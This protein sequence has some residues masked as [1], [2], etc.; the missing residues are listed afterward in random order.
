[1]A[2]IRTIKPEAFVSE[3][4]T[5][6]TLTAERTFFG[7]LT[8]ADDQGRYRDHAAIIAGQ[9]WVLRPEHTPAEVEK[10]L[11]QLA[12]AGLVCRYKGP[13]DK[14]YLH[15]VTWHKHQK[16]NRASKSRIP[17]CPRHNDP[18]GAP[19][20]T[21]TVEAVA[22]APSVTHG[23]VADHAPNP[24]GGDSEGARNP[25]DPSN[26][27]ET[28]NKT[29]GQ[30]AVSEPSPEPHGL[31]LEAAVTPHGPDL[32]PRIMDLGSTP[33]GG[34]SAPAASTVSAKQLIAEYSAACAHRPPQD[35]LGH[36]GREVR[37]L[38]AEGIAPDHIRAGLVLHRTKGKHPSILPSL[39]HEAMNAALA[40]PV[41]HRPWTNPADAEAAYGEQ[42]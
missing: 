1:M 23:A 18:N 27:T 21:K 22:P 9:L 6:V 15:I 30:E 10:D 12:D 19:G 39:V 11:A 42:L 28:T 17:A 5:V 14:R 20:G 29:A 13:D 25:H 33:S 37:K 41:I 40:Q 2:R 34:A 36:L 8:Q 3:S 4:L 32:G 16:I 24:H 31:V 35:V 7:L 38:L 26:Q